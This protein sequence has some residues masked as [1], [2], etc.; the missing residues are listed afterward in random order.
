MDGG[1]EAKATAAAL[2]SGHAVEEEDDE[3]RARAAGLTERDRAIAEWIERV[4]VAGVDHVARR[5]G[6]GRVVAWRRLATLC[7]TGWIRSWRPF[8]G[9]GSGIQPEPVT[10][11]T[12]TTSSPWCR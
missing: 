10:C 9:E 12:S 4:G 7:E 11:A 6:V 1:E 3:E 5:F 8:A 2:A